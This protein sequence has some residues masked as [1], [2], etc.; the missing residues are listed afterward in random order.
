[1][2]DKYWV[3]SGYFFY[4]LHTESYLLLATSFVID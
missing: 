4:L 2:L 3:G 1:L